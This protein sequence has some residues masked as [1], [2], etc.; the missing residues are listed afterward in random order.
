MDALN[1][2]VSRLWQRCL[3][4]GDLD[5]M[6]TGWRAVLGFRSSHMVLA[7]LSKGWHP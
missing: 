7:Q 3:P 5:M 1:P 2:R 6:E 4:E